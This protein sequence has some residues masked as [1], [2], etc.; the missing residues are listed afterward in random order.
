MLFAPP[1]DLSKL[2]NAAGR[3]RE[4]GLVGLGAVVGVAAGAVVA[5]MGYLTHGLHAI[6]FGIEI[7]DR[8]SA[9]LK[10]AHVSMVLVPALG[11]ILIG[12]SLWWA[13]ARGARRPVDPIEAN[14]L[15]GGRMSIRDSLTVAVQTV[16][17]SG[18][19]ASVGL[20]AGYTQASSSL[21]SRLAGL[22]R[23]K[24]ADVRTLVGCGAA[25]AIS[26][27]FGAP[28]AGAFYAFE[29][30]I[31]SYSVAIVSPVF[32]AALAARLTASWLGADPI[33]IDLGTDVAISIA[34]LPIFLPLGVL[35]GL[36][37]VAT[38]LLVTWSERAF[39]ACSCP[40]P[41]RPVLGGLAVGALGYW[42]PQVLASGHGALHLELA[43]QLSV[44]ALA[45]VFA[46][47]TI[48]AALSLGSGF[49]GGLFFSSLFLGSLLGKLYVAVLPMLG[50]SMHV[51]SMLAAIVGMAAMAVGAV[52]GPLTMTFLACETS[53]NW[54]ILGVVLGAVITS[55][56]VVRETFGYSFSTWRMH[57]RGETIRSAHDVGRI[58]SLTV[59]AMMRSDV[60]TVA[61]DTTIAQFRAEFPLGAAQRVVALDAEGRYAGIVIV[62]DAHARD[63]AAGDDAR[64][65]DL[66]VHRN[67]V[68]TPAMT[69][70]EAAHLFR[71]A[72]SEE[73]AVVENPWNR[74]VVGLLTEQHL[75]R[76]YA[77][78]LDRTRR[79]LAGEN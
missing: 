25:G 72:K 8:L 34:E 36:A 79:D 44:G 41:L 13:R 21:A 2:A 26:A 22:F 49:R 64:V 66:L 43:L 71:L 35:G 39:R 7:S 23:L 45:L 75:L 3:L 76:R 62:V 18:F 73:L 74:N 20:E 70:E 69:A 67:V 33:P 55:A 14:A 52:G 19:G 11:G 5:A 42:S 4:I 6:L 51:P 54:S 46:L 53:N 16:I 63:K 50:L 32:A 68:L 38:M 17:S 27:A 58:R 31:G 47:K 12:L 60:R 61:A 57:L 65:T 30:I 1:T 9:Q 40:Q 77:E 37:A 28:F 24:R 59:G 15:T 29:L 56:I 10:L 48:A 78:E